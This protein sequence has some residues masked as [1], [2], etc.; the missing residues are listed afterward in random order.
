MSSYLSFPAFSQHDS[1]SKCTPGESTDRNERKQGNYIMYARATRGNKHNNNKF[2]D[3]SIQSIS[4]VL[5]K[6]RGI[7][8]VGN[9]SNEYFS[10]IVV[11]CVFKINNIL[12]LV[13][14]VCTESGEPSC[15]NGLVEEGEECDC[16]YDECNDPCCY[17]ANEEKGK[18]CTIKPGAEC[19]SN[20]VVLD[21]LA[22]QEE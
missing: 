3:C 17:S 2:S 5:A 11:L 12:T 22:N 14:F 7:C 8:F 19:R 10:N 15:G 1:E 16:G 13:L 9:F 4:S 6:K 18:R 20:F 21:C